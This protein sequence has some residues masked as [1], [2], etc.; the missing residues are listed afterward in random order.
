M[1]FYWPILYSDGSNSNIP[2]PFPHIPQAT[3]PINI[4]QETSLNPEKDKLVEVK[5]EMDPNPP[6]EPM[7]VQEE[8]TL[9]NN[10]SSIQEEFV[11]LIQDRQQCYLVLES[12][13]EHTKVVGFL[14]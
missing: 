1:E 10:T 2:F 14:P 7:D 11:L 6:H 13:L 3:V 5:G 9:E 8:A 12:C 4:P